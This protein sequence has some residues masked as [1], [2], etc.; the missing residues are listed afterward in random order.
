MF[1]L[2]VTTGRIEKSEIMKCFDLTKVEFINNSPSEDEYKEKHYA[3]EGHLE[4][5]ADAARKL[6]DMSDHRVNYALMLLGAR[7]SLISTNG[8]HGV[9][10]SRKKL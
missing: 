8:T 6:D 9:F 3:F 10:V 1:T 7:P 2:F 5:L 4:D